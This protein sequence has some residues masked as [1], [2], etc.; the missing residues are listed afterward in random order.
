MKTE[1]KRT[2]LPIK[3]I[4][5]GKVYDTYCEAARAVNGNRWG[6]RYCAMGIQS[7]HMGQHF[8]YVKYKRKG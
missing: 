7:S 2:H 8:K 5:S 1:S 3:H 4:E 6:V